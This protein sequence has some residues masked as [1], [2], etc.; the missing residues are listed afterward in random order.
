MN[1]VIINN[2]RLK[3]DEDGQIFSYIKRGNSNTFK[4][5]LISGG[6][7]GAGYKSIGINKKI[8]GKH[9]VVYKLNNPDWN[10][11]D[12]SNTNHIDHIDRNPLNNKIENLRVVSK[13]QNAFNKNCRGYYF[14]KNLNK[15]IAKITANYEQHYLGCFILECEA[16]EAYL[17]AKKIYHVITIDADEVN[18]VETTDQKICCG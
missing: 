2:T 8:Y 15:W 10:I 5:H 4:W 17:E 6:N 16:R 3:L 18:E 1:E 14:N 7:N 12:N 11:T 9:R 13:K